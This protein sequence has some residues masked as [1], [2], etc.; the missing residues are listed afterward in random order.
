[1]KSFYVGIPYSWACTPKS[2]MG[3][4]L[5]H[6][7]SQLQ[8]FLI[9]QEKNIFSQNFEILLKITYPTTGSNFA[10]I[11]NEGIELFQF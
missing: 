4:K 10:S 11:G 5:S 9:W 8:K 1:M 2:K 6:F 7:A 3:A